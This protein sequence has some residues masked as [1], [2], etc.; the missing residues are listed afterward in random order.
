MCLLA[1]AAGASV[2]DFS[3]S[4]RLADLSID[5]AGNVVVGEGEDARAVP[6]G[7]FVA[8]VA[9]RQG[10]REDRGFLYR[11]FDITGWTGFAWVG[12]GLLGQLLFSGRMIVQWLASERRKQSVVPVAFW[13]MSLA[14]SSML[15]VYFTWR[16]EVIGLLGQAAPWAIYVR[17]LWL[18]YRP[19]A[20]P[21]TATAAAA[22]GR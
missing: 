10:E 11:F 12:L 20:A 18:I 16:V 17:N 3:L 7:E 5:D 13:W 6:P 1:T 2:G 14:G 22:P 8:A 21:V 4:D 19:K 15:L 9:A